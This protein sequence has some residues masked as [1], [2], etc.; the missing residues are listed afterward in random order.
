MPFPHEVGDMRF[1]SKGDRFM[2]ANEYIQFNGVCHDEYGKDSLAPLTTFRPW[3]KWN[4]PVDPVM[5]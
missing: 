1:T 5:M 4:L 2:F 3:D